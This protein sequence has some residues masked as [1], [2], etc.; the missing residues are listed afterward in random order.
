MVSRDKEAVAPGDQDS[1]VTRLGLVCRQ[2]EAEDQSEAC[3]LGHMRLGLMI[4]PSQGGLEQNKS[5]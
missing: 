5:L 3:H 2:L 4:L 1:S